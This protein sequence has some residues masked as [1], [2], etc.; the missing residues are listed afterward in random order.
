MT[1]SYREIAVAAFE[2]KRYTREAS[3]SREHSAIWQWQ[4]HL[5]GHDS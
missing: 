5:S 1:R 2:L 4:I 3:Y